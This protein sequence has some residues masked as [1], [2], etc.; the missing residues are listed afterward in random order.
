MDQTNWIQTVRRA[1]QVGP[2]GT[3]TDRNREPQPPQGV[4][5]SSLSDMDS[6][7]FGFS[8]GGEGK[9][10]NT[11]RSIRGWDGVNGTVVVWDP[12]RPF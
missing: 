7:G 12:G 5:R 8:S 4:E 6:T 3:G 9:D 2:D 10:L 11:K 1:S